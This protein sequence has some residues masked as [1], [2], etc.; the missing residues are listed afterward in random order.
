MNA[1]AT[2]PW[3]DAPWQPRPW[4][5][6]ALPLVM[7]ALRSRRRGVVSACTGSGKSILQAEVC[8]QVL[9][10][11][12]AKGGDGW[13]VVVTVPSQHLTEQ[14]ASTLRRRLGKWSVGRWYGQRKEL[15]AVTVCCL[16]SLGTLADE[17]AAKGLRVAAW[18]AD[19]CHKTF[20]DQVQEQVERLAPVARVGFTATP[21]RTAKHEYLRGFDDLLMRYLIG[22]AI[23]DAA[24]VP[25]RVEWWKGSEDDDPDEVCL[26]MI[27][28]HARGP[29]IV[30]ASDIADAE[31]YA[32]WLT[33]RD[34]PAQAIHSRL[35]GT[36]RSKLLKRLEDG[37]LAALVH[38]ALLVE[39][40]DYPWLRWLCL[41]RETQSPVRVVQEMGRV[42]RTHP[43]KTEAVILDPFSVLGKVGIR[44][45]ATFEAL[46]ERMERAEEQ[47]ANSG[48]GGGTPEARKVVAMTEVEAWLADTLFQAQIVGIAEADKY[49]RSG[50]WRAEG[51]SDKQLAT[52]ERWAS[53][54]RR[55]PTRYLPEPA[56]AHAKA[57]IT[58]RA[59]LTRGAASD[60]LTLLFGV[61]RKAIEARDGVPHG[62][63]SQGRWTWPDEVQI[64]DIDKGVVLAATGEA[65]P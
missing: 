6:R 47:D 60:L 62:D 59:S 57:L 22:D 8:H 7:D 65:A 14:L 36:E 56:R 5:G 2:K 3:A 25:P 21:F 43:G 41:R 54:W 29:G 42:L 40:V 12:R 30:S 35:T 9:Q 31:A 33:E 61:Q 48:E 20:P 11:L 19:E 23:R 55:A 53:N 28:E 63:W 10:G 18:I 39:G 27:R 51:P 34:V 49:G 13:I 4:Q 1:L 37:E 15:R 58:A 46:V 26:A 32:A 24:L 16:A 64:P 45:D 52:L 17:V 44:T 38:V 50:A